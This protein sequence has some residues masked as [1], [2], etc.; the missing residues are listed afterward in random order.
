MARNNKNT[1]IEST[2]KHYKMFKYVMFVKKEKNNTKFKIT[3]ASKYIVR[4]E[5]T[6]NNRNDF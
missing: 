3:V 2:I 5:A 6:H 4:E 1:S